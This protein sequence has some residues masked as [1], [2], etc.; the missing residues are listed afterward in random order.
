[1]PRRAGSVDEGGAL[2]AEG[3]R[4][5]RTLGF[6]R[7]SLRAYP[8]SGGGVQSSSGPGPGDLP[9]AAGSRNAARFRA[10]EHK[11]CPPAGAP[12]CSLAWRGQRGRFAKRVWAVFAGRLGP[13]TRQLVRWGRDRSSTV[14]ANLLAVS[15]AE[16]RITRVC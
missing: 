4:V 10:L 13:G 5:G 8:R 16:S 3:R 7:N 9:I 15:K 14:R 12:T 6:E 1:K 2:L 11:R